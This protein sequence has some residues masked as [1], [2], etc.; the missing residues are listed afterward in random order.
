VSGEVRVAQSLTMCRSPEEVYAF[1]RDF[2]NLARWMRAIECV[3]L[4]GPR[5][6]HWRARGVAGKRVE[7]DAEIT[8]ERPNELIAWRTLAGSGL[9]HRGQVRFC[10]APAGRGTEVQVEFWYR[11]P[12]GALGRLAATALG[13]AP[14]QQLAGDLRRLKQVLE[15]GEVML[16]DVTLRGARLRQGPAQPPRRAPRTA[17]SH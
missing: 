12:G 10:A 15:T 1:W 5:S 14:E 6:S 9:A 7:W 11:P 3:Q 8:D 17:L 2:Q 16:S 4:S 13:R